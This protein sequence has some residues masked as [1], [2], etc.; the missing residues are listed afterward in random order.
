MRPKVLLLALAALIAAALVGLSLA[1]RRRPVS[2]LVDGRLRPC[3]Q[4]PNCV[5]SLA[6]DER[7]AVEPL[8]F[9]GD[10][11]EAFARLVGIVRSAP[12]TELLRLED[13]YAHF[14]VTTALMRYRDDV[15]LHLD[16]AGGVVHVRSSSRVG[17]GDL[18]A[19]RARVES[20]RARFEG[21]LEER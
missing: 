14:E 3:P 20:I 21:T 4:T 1:S 15:E 19:N 16:E 12:R 2:G 5:S 7:H 6:T 8:R 9:R 17:H 11:H 10:P 18:G 13:S